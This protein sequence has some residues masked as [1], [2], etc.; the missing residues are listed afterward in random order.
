MDGLKMSLGN[1]HGLRV[2]AVMTCLICI[3]A[4]NDE[5]HQTTEPRIYGE[6]TFSSTF[7]H[8]QIAVFN[9]A[10]DNDTGY[11]AAVG[12]VDSLGTG[13]KSGLIVIFD[14]DGSIYR[15]WTL[16]N[17]TVTSLNAVVFDPQSRRFIAVGTGGGT[18]APLVSF[19]PESENI[20]YSSWQPG[21]RVNV[22]DIV[23]TDDDKLIVCGTTLASGSQA[24]IGSLNA[25]FSMD[26]LQLHNM[27]VGEHTASA[28]TTLPDGFAVTGW[29][30]NADSLYSWFL[31][32][33][34]SGA[35]VSVNK[36]TGGQ[37]Q[38]HDITTVGDT[39]CFIVGES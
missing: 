39:S 17:S 18:S 11:V 24:F 38:V 36:F 23:V 15:I 9:D 22:S 2:L 29:A 33:D 12:W 14:I 8:G 20:E 25:S 6:H 1:Q 4:C 28:I 26:W 35:F 7:E 19:D 5:G 21:T 34:R 30:N 3:I 37:Y 10:V 13:T 27:P 31:S 16:D 32:T